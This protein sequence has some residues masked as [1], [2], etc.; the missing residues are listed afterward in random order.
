[1]LCFAIEPA[2]HRLGSISHFPGPVPV[3]ATSMQTILFPNNRGLQIGRHLT[4]SNLPN[5]RASPGACSP[6]WP[7]ASSATFCALRC[8]S[9]DSPLSF[10][11]PSPLT[12]PPYRLPRPP[13]NAFLPPTVK[14]VVS[15]FAFLLGLPRSR[16]WPLSC[17]LRLFF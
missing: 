12:L 14:H 2:P 16:P 10:L 13:G 17:L 6:S 15:R 4:L 3:T 1:M 5:I 11:P 8:V 9:V 7:S